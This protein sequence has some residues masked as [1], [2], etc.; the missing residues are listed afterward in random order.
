MKRA[1]CLSCGEWKH[2]PWATC[3]KCGFDPTSDPLLEAKSV[4]LSLGRYAGDDYMHEYYDELEGY[5]KRIKR[6]ESIEFPQDE[7]HRLLE[8][9]RDVRSVSPAQAYL[10]LL[11][12]IWP[13][14]LIIIVAG[15][16]FV[17]RCNMQ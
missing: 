3:K 4:F 12:N 9:R 2:R 7:I 13:L 17:A 1:I 11:F 14:L 16:I 15:T 8:E 5:S 6:G 10:A